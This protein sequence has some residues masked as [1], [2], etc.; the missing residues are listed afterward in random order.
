MHNATFGFMYYLLTKIVAIK[1]NSIFVLSS[2]SLLLISLIPDTSSEFTTKECQY[3]MKTFNVTH[4]QCFSVMGGDEP[5]CESGK[6]PGGCYIQNTPEKLCLKW[7][8]SQQ[9]SCWMGDENILVDDEYGMCAH[10]QS[11]ISCSKELSED[12]P[13]EINPP[14]ASTKAVTSAAAHHQFGTKIMAFGGFGL[15][16]APS[17]KFRYIFTDHGTH[18][19]VLFYAVSKIVT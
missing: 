1:M 17:Y 14:T 9:L 12:G 3:K 5:L 2:V 19:G 13:Q 18:M 16:N 7:R 15:P 4:C 11:T 8:S 6:P 10:D